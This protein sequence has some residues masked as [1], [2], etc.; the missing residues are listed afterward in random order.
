MSDDIVSGLIVEFKT[1]VRERFLT[2]STLEVLLLF[3]AVYLGWDAYALVY[4]YVGRWSI[5]VLPWFLKLPMMSYHFEYS[6]VSWTASHR[7]IHALLR[8][9]YSLGF[10]G[11]ILLTFFYLLLRS[12]RDARLLVKRYAVAMLVLAL[13]FITFHVYAPHVVYRLPERYAPGD[14]TA[15]PEFVLPSP[16]NTLA[17]VSFVTLLDR[18]GKGALPLLIFIALIPPA[19]VLLGEHWVWD[20]VTGIL[21]GF[22]VSRYVR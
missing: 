18:G 5:N 8:K 12:P 21:I 6:L 10:S 16:H 4:P 17:T 19:T 15:R 13:S 9:V 1:I 11:E 7:L 22:L 2:R 20:A 14:W 3:L